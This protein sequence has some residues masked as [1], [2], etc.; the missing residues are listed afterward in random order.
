LAKIKDCK[1]K[2]DT[3][4]KQDFFANKNKAK[5]GILGHFILQKRT[6]NLPQFF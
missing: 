4:Y 3:A 2:K 1:G 5:K 6:R